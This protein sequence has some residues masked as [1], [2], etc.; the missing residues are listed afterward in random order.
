[1]KGFIEGLSE[2]L[3]LHMRDIKTEGEEISLLGEGWEFITD[4]PWRITLNGK[5]VLSS[6]IQQGD[7]VVKSILLSSIDKI[8]TQSVS[9]EIDPIFY[10]SNGMIL[11]IFSINDFE[12]WVFDVIGSKIYVGGS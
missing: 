7:E 9:L 8:G 11:E 12:F 1:M 4:N 6:E 3:P 5:V 10:F 2:L